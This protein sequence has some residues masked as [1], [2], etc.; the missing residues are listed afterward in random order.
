MGNDFKARAD[1]LKPRE[2]IA[3]AGTTKG[4]DAV[5]LLATILKTGAAGCDVV[6]LARRLIDAFGGVEPLVAC[7]LNELRSGVA[8][9][10]AAHPDRKILGF[11][12]VKAL[13]LAAAFEFARRGRGAAAAAR[14]PLETADD[15]AAVF[16]AALRGDETQEKF[17]VLPLDVRRRPLSAPLV[18]AVGTV[19]GVSV[20]PRDVFAAAVK[21]NAKSVVVAHNHPSGSPKPSARDRSLTAALDAAGKMM[22]IAL[23]DHVILG[24]RTHYSFAETHT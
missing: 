7:D 16:R 3:R 1:D 10:N 20:H 23:L 19:D 24:A 17:L 15:A 8:A 22:G 2:R 4:A 5:D 18:V 13:V 9:Y 6:E 12:P 11:G 14:E 21:W